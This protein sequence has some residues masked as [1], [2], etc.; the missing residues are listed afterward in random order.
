MLDVLLEPLF[1][2]QY[3]I[4]AIYYAESYG[5]FATLI[6]AFSFVTTTI[7]YIITYIS[8]KKIKKMAEK[9]I[10]VKVLRNGNF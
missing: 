7:N 9:I 10:D 4:C 8:Y 2:V 6:L 3:I 1:L 5:M